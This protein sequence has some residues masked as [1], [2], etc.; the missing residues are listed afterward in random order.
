[1]QPC[2]LMHGIA[3]KEELNKHSEAGK[4]RRTYEKSL[5]HILENE[6]KEVDDRFSREKKRCRE[7]GWS[8]KIPEH[9]KPKAEALEN[10]LAQ[11]L[12]EA[13]QKG[14]QGDIAGSQKAM[15]NVES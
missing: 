13:E 4:Y 2:K 5:L 10:D 6:V 11:Q 12:K 9:H 1:M 8:L 7:K 15:D 14:S 3:M